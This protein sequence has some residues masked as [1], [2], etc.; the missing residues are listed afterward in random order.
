MVLDGSTRRTARSVDGSRPTIVA[1][2][3]SCF[4][5]RTVTSFDVAPSTTCALVRMSPRL[6]SA[7]PDPVAVPCC[8]PP[9]NDGVL[10]RTFASTYA[11][12]G[13]TRL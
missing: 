11:T 3:G 12:P 10:L 6:S 5:N 9:N 1:L 7:N 8:V 4:P 2:T 13:P